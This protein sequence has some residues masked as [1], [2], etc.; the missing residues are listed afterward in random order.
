MLRCG[1]EAN[2]TRSETVVGGI[3]GVFLIHEKCGQL[4]PATAVVMSGRVR[5]LINKRIP[6]IAQIPF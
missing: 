4:S 6:C 2:F 1:A 3:I 5:V